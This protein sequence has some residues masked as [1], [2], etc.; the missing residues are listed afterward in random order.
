M[1]R[2]KLRIALLETSI[3]A[4]IRKQMLKFNIAR[5]T[6][7]KKKASERKSSEHL[8]IFLSKKHKGRYKKLPLI[9][10]KF[11][12]CL[13]IQMDFETRFCTDLS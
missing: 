10:T 8:T 13:K 4:Q 1:L 3:N 9:N 6:I 5:N 2:H 7:T 11:N 12:T